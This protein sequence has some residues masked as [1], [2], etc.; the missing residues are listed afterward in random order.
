MNRVSPLLRTPSLVLERFD[1]APGLAHHDPE[2]ERA[3]SH[4]ASF[5][6]AG[7]FRLRLAVGLAQAAFSQ[8]N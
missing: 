7:S 5:V 8:H 3:R 2:W 6:D 4:A 1:H